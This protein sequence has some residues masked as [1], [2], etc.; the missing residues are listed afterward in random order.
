MK[1][2]FSEA[3]NLFQNGKLNKAKNICEEIL[4]QEANNS[5]VYNLYAFTLHYLE[6]FDAAVEYWSKAIKINPNYANAYNN[7][8]STLNQLGQ[9]DHRKKEFQ[10]II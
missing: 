5:Q 7:M 1:S 2:K 3:L 4:K 6:K 9:L 8:G 10:K